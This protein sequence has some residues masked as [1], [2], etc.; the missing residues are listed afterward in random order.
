VVYAEDGELRGEFLLNKAEQAADLLERFLAQHPEESFV[1]RVE[2][3]ASGEGWWTAVRPGGTDPASGEAW[4]RA[5]IAR[6][7]SRSRS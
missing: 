1:I 4:T 3:A 6:T 2:L 5:V 7:N